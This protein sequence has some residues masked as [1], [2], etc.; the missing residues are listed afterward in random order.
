RRR[1][2]NDPV[3][4]AV[5][6]RRVTARAAA[7]RGRA[8][9]SARAARHRAARSRTGVAGDGAADHDG[10]AEHERVPAAPSNDVGARMEPAAADPA[11]E[12]QPVYADVDPQLE[13]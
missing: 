9:A 7:A 13:A 6:G 8:A 10:L 3:R 2:R 1:S 11:G 12:A 4:T 5:A